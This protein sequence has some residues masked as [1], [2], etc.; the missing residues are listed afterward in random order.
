RS[1]NV[2]RAMMEARRL[3]SESLFSDRE[4]SLLAQVW[5][6]APEQ[7]RANA[8]ALVSDRIAK[9]GLDK[10]CDFVVQTIKSPETIAALK[11]F[12]AFGET[13]VFEQV[14]VRA[15]FFER[16]QKYN[17]EVSFILRNMQNKPHEMPTIIICNL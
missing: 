2:L 8:K 13:F 14:A 9:S 4:F 1:A 10:F 11:K 16:I 5:S 17:I 15:P 3:C 6:A 7:T 12:F